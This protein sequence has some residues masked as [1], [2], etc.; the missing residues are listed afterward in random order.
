VLAAGLLQHRDALAQREV[1]AAEVHVEL[2]VELLR[3]GLR[4]RSPDA[5]ARVVDQHVE[6]AEAVAVRAHDAL[7][8]VLLGHVRGD[9][10][11]VDALVDQ[12]LHGRLEL[13]RPPRRDGEA[14]AVL[15]ERAGDRESDAARPARDDRRPVRH[16]SRA[17]YTRAELRRSL[18]TAAYAKGP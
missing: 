13:L 7:D 8:V 2:H 5:D 10:L 6:A 14:V 18:G 15:P 17:P 1:D 4:D 3:L 16:R 11:R 9:R 12:A